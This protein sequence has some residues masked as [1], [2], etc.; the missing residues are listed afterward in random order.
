VQIR[1]TSNGMLIYKEKLCG[2]ESSFALADPSRAALVRLGI[3]LGELGTVLAKDHKRLK[4]EHL[5]LL[6]TDRA[7][8]SLP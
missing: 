6:G 4:G 8:R 2:P 5:V 7:P 1:W 3:P